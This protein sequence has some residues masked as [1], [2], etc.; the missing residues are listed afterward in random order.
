[1]SSVLDLAVPGAGSV[2]TALVKI[3]QLCSK[4][5]EGQDACRRVHA[6]LQEILTE[7]Q[8]ME[9]RG[10]LP[11]RDALDKYV[12]VVSEY[13]QYLERYCDKTLVSRLLKHQAMMAALLTINEDVDKLFRM[14]NLAATAAVMDW[15]QQWETNRCAQ[16]QAMAAMAENGTVVLRELPDTRAQVEAVLLLRFE[17]EQR[18]A[19]QS[20][21][22]QET[23]K[24]MMRTMV[25]ASEITAKKLPPWFLPP[26]EVAVEP[27]PFARG[28]YGS[29]HRGVWG[30][31]AKVVVKRF[32]VDDSVLDEGAQQKIEA[33]MNIWHQ[34][35][36]P[37]VVKMFGASHVS[38]PPFVVC[39]EA[40][41]GNLCSFLRRSDDNQK[42]MWRLLHQAALGL[43]YIHSKR[44]VHGD[45]KLNN[46]LVGSDGK[47]R[48]ADFG[49]S[50]MRTC[51]TLSQPSA[52]APKVS[53][54]LRWRAP[55]CLR[56][57]PTFASDVYSFAM[58]MIEAAIGEPPFAFLDDDD[59]RA[60]LKDGEIPDPPEEMSD[61]VWELV[62]SM[63]HTDSTKRMKLPEVLEKLKVLA[64]AEE[65]AEKLSAAETHC[66][67]CSSVIVG[68][69]AFCCRCGSNVMSEMDALPTLDCTASVAVLLNTIATAGAAETERALLLLLRKC[70][71]RQERLQMYEANGVRVLSGVV[72]T[73][74]CY[75]AQ[76]YA[77]ESLGWATFFDS[78]L[79]RSEYEVLR[80]CIRSATTPELESMVDVLLHG[81]DQEKEDGLILCAALTTRGDRDALRQVGVVPPL[82]EMLRSGSVM[83]QLWATEILGTLAANNDVNREVIAREGVITPLVGLV[84][85]GTDDQKMF[86]TYALGNLAVNEANQEVVARDGGISPLVA[87]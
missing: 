54:G 63:T 2:A 50:A 3:L 74:G 76:L 30:A 1:M 86:A 78:K 20:T 80:D 61:D 47:A 10:Q 69:S 12:A 6:R 35:N 38:S 67:V 83:Q 27:I 45:L 37:Y 26:D 19:R 24:A 85:V 40:S 66:S 72:T 9:E 23:M 53:G 71:D 84:R 55:E 70:T 44:V 25:R 56:R 87:L 57:R 5:K 29:V 7:L 34:L 8:A 73:G 15:K 81:T 64:D 39:E 79:S 77:L 11:P 82:V 58:C 17:V 68:E 62:V 33:E 59:V 60:A 43:E 22:M 21:A 65:A 41:N 13:L 46:I 16:K 42:R 28:S 4:M 36:H 31:G 52:D 48:L 75:V 32:L 51:S 18:A 14:P 49:L